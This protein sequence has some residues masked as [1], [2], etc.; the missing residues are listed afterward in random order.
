VRNTPK[1]EKGPDRTR[2]G[3]PQLTAN[4]IE[5]PRRQ[6]RQETRVLASLVPWR[7]RSRFVIYGQDRAARSPSVPGPKRWHHGHRQVDRLRARARALS[8]TAL[9]QRST[10]FF[11]NRKER[12]D[13]KNSGPLRPLRSLRS[14]SRLV[15]PC[16]AKT[17]ALTLLLRGGAWKASRN[18]DR[19]VGAREI[20]G[21]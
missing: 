4:V 12:N 8:S 21:G 3:G 16:Q 9:V 1:R 7:S 17:H 5:P 19:N 10:T 15:V 20:G 13:A 2:D 18:H 11:S 14:K 6:G